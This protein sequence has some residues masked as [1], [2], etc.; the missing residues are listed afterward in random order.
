MK[1]KWNKSAYQQWYD[2]AEQSKKAK[3]VV[4]G[5]PKKK[6]EVYF[7]LAPNDWVYLPQSEVFFKFKAGWDAIYKAPP[8]PEEEY[9]P[10]PEIDGWWE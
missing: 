8:K 2:S 9:N 7:A 6:A 10:H 4:E 1:N 5:N 3:G